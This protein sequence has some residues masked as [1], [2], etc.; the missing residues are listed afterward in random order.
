M[1][2][3]DF[4]IYVVQEVSFMSEHEIDIHLSVDDL[5]ID[6]EMNGIYYLKFTQNNKTK[7]V[8]ITLNY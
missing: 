3:G 6:A 8:S 2:S 7:V 4:D 5:I 1:E